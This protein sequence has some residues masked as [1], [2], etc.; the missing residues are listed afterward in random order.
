MPIYK[1]KETGELCKFSR[2][3]TYIYDDGSKKEIDLATGE[4]ITA[5]WELHTEE[6][7]YKTIAAKKSNNDGRGIR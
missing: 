1:N 7:N 2:T 5:N 4:D 6:T 3:R